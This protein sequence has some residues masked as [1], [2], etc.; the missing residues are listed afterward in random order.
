MY[1]DFIYRFQNACGWV[2]ENKEYSRISYLFHVK[3][4]IFRFNN[5]KKITLYFLKFLF[6]TEVGYRQEKKREG[7]YRKRKEIEKERTKLLL[8]R[9]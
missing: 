3:R 9:S 2:L 4:I 7:E 6:N 8:S 1:I 5:V